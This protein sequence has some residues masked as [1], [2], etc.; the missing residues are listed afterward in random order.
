MEKVQI[1]KD[2]LVPENHE[3]A[4]LDDTGTYEEN[5]LITVYQVEDTDKK[6]YSKFEARFI[7]VGGDIYTE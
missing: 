4:V 6:P 2:Q 7:A 5:E 1:T 3:L